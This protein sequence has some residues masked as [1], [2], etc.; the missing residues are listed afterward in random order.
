MEELL[1]LQVDLEAALLV[2]VNNLGCDGRDVVLNKF[3]VST[4]LSGFG[5]ACNGFGTDY[6]IGLFMVLTPAKDSPVM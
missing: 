5:C 6:P 4:I 3:T 2:H 1:T